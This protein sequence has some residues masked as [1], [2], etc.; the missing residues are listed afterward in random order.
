MTPHPPDV[1]D[2]VIDHL[3]AAETESALDKFRGGDFAGRVRRK[4]D[5][6]P[7]PRRRRFAFLGA[8]PR[9]AW[10]A[11]TAAVLVG[12]ALL[13]F[14]PEKKQRSQIASTIEDFLRQA[15]VSQEVE[16]P[17]A[18]RPRAEEDRVSPA[19]TAIVTAL[20]AG[21]QSASAALKSAPGPKS[22]GEAKRLRPLGLEEMYKI[23]F[24][25]KSVERVLK[26]MSS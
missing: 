8:V 20:L 18:K 3:I 13:L 2:S 4:I 11:M 22:S 24:I 6:G 21:K 23:L 9:A 7:P 17:A 14:P 15:P 12:A 26:L 1:L 25:D 16:S 19:E 10:V 5:T